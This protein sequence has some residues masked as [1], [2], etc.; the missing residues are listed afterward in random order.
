MMGTNSNHLQKYS[1]IYLI[2][3]VA[4]AALLRILYLDSILQT[5][6]DRYG[7][8]LPI[9]LKAF[10]KDTIGKKYIPLKTVEELNT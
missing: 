4:I 1:F 5:G 10:G 7:S 9:L 8:F 3:I 6:R 2:G